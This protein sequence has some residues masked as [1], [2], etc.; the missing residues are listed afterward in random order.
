[1]CARILSVS[2]PRPLAL[3][4]TVLAGRFVE[5]LVP[6]DEALIDPRAPR[7]RRG[8]E[9]ACAPEARL[10]QELRERQRPLRESEPVAW[11]AVPMGIGPGHDRRVGRERRRAAE[12]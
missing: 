3:V 4:V 2:V 10:V 1:M 5:V 9:E 6:V 12:A 8:A 11:D 7:E